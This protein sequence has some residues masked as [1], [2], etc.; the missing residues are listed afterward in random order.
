MRIVVAMSGGVDSSVVAA[1]MAE[2]GH[3]VIGLTMQLYDHGAATGRKGACCAG[4][5][6]HD[7][8]TTADRLG[9]AHYVL[10]F[11]QR[12]RDAVIAPFA[13]TY[14]AGETP[15]P[16]IRCNQRLKFE[17]LLEVARDLGAEA[18]AT[19]HYARRE[20]TPD[21]PGLFRAHDDSRDQSWFLGLTTR[22]QLGFVRFPLG[23]WPKSRV[24]AEAARFGLAVAEK[25]DS[26]DICFV[27]AGRYDEVVAK[28]RPDAARPG[29]IVLGTGEVVGR[30]PGLARFTIGQARGL[31]PASFERP[32]GTGERRVVLR[33]DAAE[34]RVVV[35]PK[36]H[37]GSRELQLNEMNWLVPAPASGETIACAAKLR[38]RDT[39][40]PALVR[41]GNRDGTV[42]TLAEP[43]VGAPGQACVL[44]HASGRVLGAGVMAK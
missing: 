24:R 16:C 15:V 2:A 11:E 19:G 38:S 34:N 22:E 27:P 3:E 26:Q 25:P 18:L 36:A 44:Y 32:D 1:L 30:H 8:R 35:G 33:L 37:L 40:R 17:D 20:D 42:V 14:A 13:A 9:L 28:L 41:A 12:F 31:G 23:A 21:G 4:Q 7:A 29:D 10:D 5:D 43:A 6:I 39:L